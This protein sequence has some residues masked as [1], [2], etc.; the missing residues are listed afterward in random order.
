MDYEEMWMLVKRR[1]L[2]ILKAGKECGQ[3]PEDISLYAIE[4]MLRLMEHEEMKAYYGEQ[5]DEPQREKQ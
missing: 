5:W 4:D 2:L 3:K 1:L